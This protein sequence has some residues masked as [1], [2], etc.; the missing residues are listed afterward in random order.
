MN[1]KSADPWTVYV[2][3]CLA[4]DKR[5]VGITCKG[6]DFRWKQ[7]VRA[8]KRNKR[9][10]ALQGAILKY[11]EEAFSIETI[12]TVANVDLAN[13]AE[14]RYIAEIKT[15]WPDGYNMNDGGEARGGFAWSEETKAKMRA[16]ASGREILPETRVKLSAAVKARWS[17]P[18]YRNRVH[19]GNQSPECMAKR[20]FH[21]RR[22]GLK[23]GGQMLGKKHTAEARAKMSAAQMGRPA[24]NKG[25]VASDAER[26]V[27]RMRAAKALEA[28]WADPQQREKLSQ[29][30]KGRKMSDEA[31]AKLS[32]SRRRGIAERR[33]LADGAV[34]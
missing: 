1:L 11:G 30:M 5:Y 32:A 13:D 33:A 25:R 16:A 10:G 34:E 3:T 24:W 6:R 28:R 9:T 18:E 8:A 29:A 26:E 12:E 15:A 20:Q 23:Y 27:L 2:I 31:R 19:Q 22:T 7:H 4:N 17:D 21:G 14:R